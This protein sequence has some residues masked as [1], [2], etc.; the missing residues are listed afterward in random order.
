MNWN[1]RVRQVH[2]WISIVFTFLVLVNIA[3]NVLPLAPEEVALWVGVSTLI[4]LVLLMITG[5]YLFALPYTDGG[6]SGEPPVDGS[7]NT[8]HG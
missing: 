6:R 8:I 5:L 1:R 7:G 3:L 2:R 4:P